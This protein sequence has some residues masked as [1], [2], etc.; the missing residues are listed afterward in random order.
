MNLRELY[1]SHN[2]IEAIEGLDNNVR[3]RRP[4]GG[5][6]GAAAGGAGLA[7]AGGSAHGLRA[8]G[9]FLKRKP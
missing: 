4:W 3:A 2:G 6:A 8:W 1:L 9:R 7:V 5:G